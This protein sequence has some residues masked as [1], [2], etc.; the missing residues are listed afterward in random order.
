M[1]AVVVECDYQNPQVERL[2][3]PAKSLASGGIVV[4]PTETVYGIGANAFDGEACGRIFRTKG[5]PA[6]N[7]L[8]VHVSGID[9]ARTVCD[10]DDRWVP[11]LVKFWPGPLTVVVKSSPSVSAEARAGLETVAVRSPSSPVARALISL[12][13][14]PVAAPSANLST[15]P[16]I[17]DGDSAVTE[18]GDLVDFIIVSGRSP[19]GIESTVIDLTSTPVR[20]LRSGS[21]SLEDLE[22]V[23]GKIEVTDTARGIGEDA[24]P[25]TPG[26]K[27]RHYSP[28]RPLYLISRNQAISIGNDDRFSD[29]LFLCSDEVAGKIRNQSFRL[30]SETDL[31]GVARNLYYAFRELDQRNVRGGFITMF[32]GKG[33]GLALENRI[34]KATSPLPPAISSL[35]E[36]LSN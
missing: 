8:I 5:R 14:V 3:E 35:I 16:S 24:R 19:L 29:Y 31:D 11:K 20:L 25:L 36:E 9:M 15:R 26:S 7:P 32:S 22:K 2:I 4:F 17:T 27:Y 1:K 30:G 28:V 6:D 18:L 10:L 23:F 12:S 34:R 33:M 13:G 21:T